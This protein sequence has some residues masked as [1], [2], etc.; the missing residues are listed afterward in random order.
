MWYFCHNCWFQVGVWGVFWYVM[1]YNLPIDVTAMVYNLLIHGHVVLTPARW[2]EEDVNEVNN[3]F[4]ESR[5][6]TSHNFR[7]WKNTVLTSKL[8]GQKKNKQSLW[9]MHFFT[10]PCASYGLLWIVVIIFENVLLDSEQSHYSSRCMTPWYLHIAHD[11]QKRCRVY[12]LHS[13]SPRGQNLW[14]MCLK[15]RILT[16]LSSVLQL[17]ICM[18]I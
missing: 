11:K 2:L 8:F 1:E 13:S 3:K 10:P 17:T 9:N 4:L 15:L 14:R 5:M 6:S 7:I 18:A 16:H 12:A